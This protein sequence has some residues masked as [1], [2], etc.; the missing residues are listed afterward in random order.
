MSA[1]PSRSGCGGTALHGQPN[2]PMGKRLFP[3]KHVRNT[4]EKLV[5]SGGI[6]GEKA[7]QWKAK[8]EDEEFVAKMRQRAESGDAVA[9]CHLGVYYQAGEQGLQK[10]KQEAYRWFK[11][12]ADLGHASGMANAGECLLLGLGVEKNEIHGMLL[13]THAATMGSRYGAHTLGQAYFKGKHGLPKDDA[14]AKRWLGKV[15]AGSVEDLHDDDVA[16][17]AEWLEGLQQ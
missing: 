10:N 2:E 8:L 15:A 11:R 6:E 7:A 17:A 9:M 4:I 3:A 14:Q 13:C 5:R 12:A 1:A 16:A